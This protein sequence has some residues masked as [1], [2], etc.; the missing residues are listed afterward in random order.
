MR[1]FKRRQGVLGAA[2]HQQSATENVQG[3]GVPRIGLENLVGNPLRFLRPLAIQCQHRPL[4][5]V[6]AGCTAAVCTRMQ[7]S[8]RHL[9]PTPRMA[10]AGDRLSHVFAFKIV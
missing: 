9:W 1:G 2:L 4:Q 3:L 5:S 6:I 7:G 8:V 10:R